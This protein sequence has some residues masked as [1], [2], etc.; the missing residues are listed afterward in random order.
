MIDRSIILKGIPDK[1]DQHWTTSL[2]FKN[3][4]LD[5]LG[6]KF[7]DKNCLEIGTFQGHTTRLLSYTFKKVVTIDNNQQFM[8]KACE[9]NTDRDNIEYLMGNIYE[10]GMLEFLETPTS[11]CIMDGLDKD[12]DVVFI[13]CV[14]KYSN[15]L[16][17]TF[18]SLTNFKDIYLIYDDYGS[19]PQVKRV[20]DH[21]MELGL[22]EFVTFIGHKKGVDLWPPNHPEKLAGK[23]K[24]LYDWEGIIC[25]SK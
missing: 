1:L 4:L 11:W 10:F 14:H 25:K 16:V 12:I 9:L 23:E 6:D 20:I 3:E 19:A 13:D 15:V 24:V 5:F 2:K 17:D 21:L 18:N 8:D 22:M 7:I